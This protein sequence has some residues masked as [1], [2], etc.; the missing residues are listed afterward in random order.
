MK[1]PQKNRFE[2]WGY[3]TLEWLT[4]AN[5]RLPSVQKCKLSF[6]GAVLGWRVLKPCFGGEGLLNP[7]HSASSC[8]PSSDGEIMDQ[9]CSVG[10]EGSL[11]PSTL[12]LISPPVEKGNF[13]VRGALLNARPWNL[14][15]DLWIQ[16]PRPETPD[17]R[18]QLERRPASRHG[19]T[20]DVAMAVDVAHSRVQIST[21]YATFHILYE[22][23]HTYIYKFYIQYIVYSNVVSDLD[24][25]K[26]LAN[27]FWT[28]KC[29]SLLPYSTSRIY[30]IEARDLDDLKTLWYP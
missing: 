17:R 3:S 7:K 25:W 19:R 4:R 8:T 12:T 13:S 10:D 24:C 2:I 9:G 14:N 26:D 28:I 22:C 15:S 30:Y 16:P 11:E 5:V 20:T 21:A 18:E 23:I 1:Q 29:T 6:R 27:F